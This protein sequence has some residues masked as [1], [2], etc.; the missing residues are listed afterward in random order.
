MLLNT[1]LGG[2][3]GGMRRTGL[4][5]FLVGVW[6]ATAYLSAALGYLLGGPQYDA[7][8]SPSE[9]AVIVTVL[10]NLREH[11]AEPGTL[12]LL[13]S[14]L[15]SEIVKHATFSPAL[16]RFLDVFSLIGDSNDEASRGL[17][18]HVAAYR[19][20]FPTQAP[21]PVGPVIE[22]HLALYRH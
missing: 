22:A 1:M 15:D 20:E 5:L 13:E 6:L 18:A 14:S 21:A 10:R 9:A 8:Y 7:M 17:M 12:R 19:S 4:A 3:E 16:A 11:N 2:V